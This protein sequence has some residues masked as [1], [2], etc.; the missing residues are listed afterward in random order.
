MFCGDFLEFPEGAVERPP[1]VPGQPVPD[2]SE[3]AFLGAVEDVRG[4]E[5][6][7]LNTH[8]VQPGVRH[9]RVF[10]LVPCDEYLH[11]ILPFSVL[12]PLGNRT[13]AHF[14]R[15]LHGWHGIHAGQIERYVRPSPTGGLCP[16]LIAEAPSAS[17][18]PYPSACPQSPGTPFR[19][20]RVRSTGLRCSER[21]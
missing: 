6:L 20:P 13:G 2:P 4:G 5:L 21:R 15:D 9:M 18:S 12:A 1:L 19:F 17:R 3:I 16:E 8:P 11:E 7:D 10:E 14:R